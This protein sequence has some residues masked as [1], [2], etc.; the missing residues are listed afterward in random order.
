MT[1]RRYLSLLAV[2]VP[3]A[4][5]AQAAAVTWPDSA[6]ALTWQNP[7]A[8]SAA[9]DMM[10]RDDAQ[11]YCAQLSLGGAAGWRLPSVDELR[12]LLRN[13]AATAPSG[14]CG[15]RSGCLGSSCRNDDCDGT[16]S[17]V[18]S[19]RWPDA[20]T[21]KCGAYWTSSPTSDAPGR[22][23]LLSFYDGSVHDGDASDYNYVRCVRSSAP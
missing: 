7:P 15:V 1:S 23:W 22:A 12:S 18:A 21:G 20:L 5:F 3:T 11:A 19:C 17:G 6:S 8:T 10:S 13:S 16:D 9:D 4:A 14:G 2:L